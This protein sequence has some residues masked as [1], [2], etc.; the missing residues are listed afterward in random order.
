ME[1][2]DLCTLRKELCANANRETEN[3]S[4]LIKSCL[5]RPGSDADTNAMGQRQGHESIE[6]R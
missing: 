5:A 4:V 3:V 1:T 6:F 2:R